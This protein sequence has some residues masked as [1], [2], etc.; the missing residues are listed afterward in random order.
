VANNCNIFFSIGTFSVIEP[1]ATLP[2]IAKEVSAVLV[3]INPQETILSKEADFLL[4]GYAGIIVPS[5]VKQTW[6]VNI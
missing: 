1:A 4:R 5:L 6:N 2:Y 3:E